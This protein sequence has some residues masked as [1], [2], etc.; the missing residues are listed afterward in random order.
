MNK[1][2]ELAFVLHLILLFFLV[3]YFCHSIQ[4]KTRSIDIRTM[5]EPQTRN[6]RAMCHIIMCIYIL[7]LE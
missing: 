6:A 5:C 1:E 7:I 4:G 2:I 3:F